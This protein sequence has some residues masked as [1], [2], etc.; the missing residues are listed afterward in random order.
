[1]S[2]VIKLQLNTMAGCEIQAKKGKNETE[3]SKAELSEIF[4][5]W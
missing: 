2:L 3:I 4:K 1:M 5:M